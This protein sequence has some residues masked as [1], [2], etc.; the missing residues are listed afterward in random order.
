MDKNVNTSNRIEA[1]NEKVSKKDVQNLVKQVQTRI[2]FN[3]V[4]E[5]LC[6]QVDEAQVGY[7]DWQEYM[8]DTRQKRALTLYKTYKKEWQNREEHVN[9]VL[10]FR[11]SKRKHV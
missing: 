9:D 5:N 3:R 8:E 7:E 2:D 6:A 4:T 11:D 10:E 1:V